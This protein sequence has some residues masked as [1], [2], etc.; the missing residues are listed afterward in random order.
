MWLKQLPKPNSLLFPL[1]YIQ[2]QPTA[3]MSPRMR[4]TKLFIKLQP[5][6]T[7]LD[8]FQIQTSPVQQSNG[9]TSIVL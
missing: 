3:S 5:S 9:F 8:R 4:E 7:G 6:I 2:V 1:F